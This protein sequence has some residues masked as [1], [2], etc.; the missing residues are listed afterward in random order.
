[1]LKNEGAQ[2]SSNETSSGESDSPLADLILDSVLDL[3]L[4]NLPQVVAVV[5]ATVLGSI[6]IQQI[7]EPKPSAP[8][9]EGA[10]RESEGAGLPED[11]ASGVKTN[12]LLGGERGPA[13]LEKAKATDASSSEAPSSGTP[14]NTNTSSYAPTSVSGYSGING[15]GETGSFQ[16][17]TA[18]SGGG[19]GGTGS[20]GT[21][22]GGGSG[23]NSGVRL[24]GNL[25]TL[26]NTAPTQDSTDTEGALPGASGTQA[27]SG[28]ELVAGF[29][30]TSGG[31]YSLQGGSILFQGSVGEAAAAAPSYGTQTTFVSGPTSISQ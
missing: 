8:L 6:A 14:V 30:I 24:T 16:A 11:I 10:V 28:P 5:A 18:A 26:Q 15:R 23:G 7:I 25:M 29:F 19:S 12:D 13:T 31:S 9:S 20:G 22:S 27:P 17:K 4:N 1:M 3:I 21:G 2:N